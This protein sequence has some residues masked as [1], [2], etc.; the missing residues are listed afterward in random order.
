MLDTSARLLRLLTLL[1]TQR[2]WSGTEL[3]ARLEVTARTLRRDI[4]RLRAL[5]YP[6]DG[7]TG[8]AGGYQLG[9][10]A[11]LPPLALE[12]DEA[13]AVS[14][15]LRTAASHATSG[16]EEAALRALVKLERVLPERLRQRASTLRGTILMIAPCGDRP[17]ADTLQRLAAAC[18]EHAQ[19]SFGY[20]DREGRASV[21]DC[22]PVGLVHTGYR[23][24]LVAW[25]CTRA[26]WRTFRVDRMNGS[27]S[28]GP[29]FASRA[30]PED[31]DL[32]AYVA[33]AVNSDGS[34]HRVEVVLH[35]PIE[36]MRVRLATTGAQLERIDEKRCI[37]R[38]ATRSVEGLA[39]W[40][41]NLGVEFEVVEPQELVDHL[42]KVAARI[43]RSL[44]SHS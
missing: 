2:S 27:F 18:D 3:A 11:S 17:T 26:D 8:V 40:I 29:R 25:D 28:T 6:I 32:R 39:F 5:G 7:T 34:E 19:L 14:I 38:V 9:A 12:D 21:R 36:A 43:D 10:G 20:C 31:G 35:A 44:A 22:E 33:R 4:A 24:Y 42:H 15:S 30:L 1:Q 13:L 37:L 23:W 41:A 16:M